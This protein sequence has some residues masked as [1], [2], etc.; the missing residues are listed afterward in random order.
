MT[1]KPFQ[2][3]VWQCNGHSNMQFEARGAEPSKLRLFGERNS[4][5]NF[6]ESLLIRNFPGLQ[7][8]R[9]YPFEKHAFFNEAYITPDMLCVCVTR[10][11]DMWLKSTYRSKHQ[12]WAW[13]SKTSFSQ[14]LRHEWYS[15]FSG[16]LLRQ[17]TGK[18]GL[19][20]GHELLLDR[21]PVTGRRIENVLALRSLKL[22]SYFKVPQMHKNYAFVRYEDVNADQTGFLRQFA[23]AFGLSWTGEPEVIEDN[24]S[25]NVRVR[26]GEADQLPKYSEFSPD[27]LEFIF[28]TL[29]FGIE[30]AFGYRY[31]PDF[32]LAP[33]T[34]LGDRTSHRISH[35]ASA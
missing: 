16:H 24:L 2:K 17:K 11:A 7:L 9:E 22:S 4:G 13:A 33:E 31:T 1:A 14:F 35:A 21:H 20:R 5:T 18:L 34:V 27:D 32:T 25:R 26:K 3:A 12:I 28:D 8:L 19:R 23:E 29:E 15:H 10:S 30:E 6:V